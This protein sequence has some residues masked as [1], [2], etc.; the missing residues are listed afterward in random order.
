MSAEIIDLFEHR[1]RRRP[2]AK[3]ISICVTDRE[4]G[5]PVLLMISTS[6]SN[7][8]ERIIVADSA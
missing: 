1:E 3:V 5:S 4:T 2:K 8:F 6:E 7:T